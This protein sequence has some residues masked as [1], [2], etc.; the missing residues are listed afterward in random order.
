MPDDVAARNA[1]VENNLPRGYGEVASAWVSGVKGW[2]VQ[3]RP[4]SLR[5]AAL[6]LVR[7]FDLEPAPVR[8][9]EK[10]NG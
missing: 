2:K 1:L 3:A 10:R 5:E 7:T 6:D 4:M 9:T 8:P